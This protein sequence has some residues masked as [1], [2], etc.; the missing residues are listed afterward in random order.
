MTYACINYLSDGVIHTTY[1][2]T[3]SLLEMMTFLRDAAIPELTA[4]TN[5]EL[6]SVHIQFTP[7]NGQGA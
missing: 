7:F 2:A 6:L 1:T 3:A 5:N 4:G